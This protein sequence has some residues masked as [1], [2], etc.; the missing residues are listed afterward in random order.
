[1]RKSRQTRRGTVAVLMALCLMGVMGFAALSLDAALLHNDRRSAQA[2]ADA[3]AL[4]AANNLFANYRTNLGADPTGSAANEARAAAAADGFNN[5]GTTSTVVVNIP[6]LSGDH[7]GQAG[8][9]EVII[10]Q[11]QQ[12]AFSAIWGS[13]ALIVKA[14]AVAR[15]TWLPSNNGI[16]VLDP[17]GS[18]SLTSNGGAAA[19][20]TGK[21]I[22][23]SNS[24][25]GLVVTG[26]GSLTSPEFD[27]SGTPGWNTSGGGTINGPILSGQQ[28]TPDPLAYLPEPDPSTMTVQSTKQVK[29]QNQGSLSLLPGV[30]TGGIS[31]TGGNLTLA[32]G[33]YYIDGGGFGFSG[34]GNLTAAG[35]MIVNAPTKNSTTDAITI[36]GSG[37]INLSPMTTGIYQGISLWQTRTSTNT[38]TIS[39]G[40][41]GSSLSGTFYAQH[42]TLKVA[43]G[44][45][46]GVGSQY[47][48]Y[49]LVITGNSAMGVNYNPASVAPVRI[50]QLV[51]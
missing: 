11:Y 10:T 16:L 50:I 1:M 43:G 12:R 26:G 42:G 23:D 5:D 28:P 22:V 31:V 46:V 33:I 34:T 49:D 4:A 36:T 8:Y 21:I 40:G 29:L 24:P 44:N 15:G 2:A 27:L 30:Y 18:G 38:L 6:P 9:A 37:V 51:E 19:A 47:I 7:V 41:A 25:T 32:P 17:T 13:D 39:G 35:V 48:S 3:A 45:G 14:R 20:T